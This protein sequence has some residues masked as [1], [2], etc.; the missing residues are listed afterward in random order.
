MT[1]DYNI[2]LTTTYLTDFNYPDS[3][4]ACCYRY[5]FPIDFLIRKGVETKTFMKASVHSTHETPNPWT[6]TFKIVR[7]W[8][9]PRERMRFGFFLLRSFC[10]GKFITRTTCARYSFWVL[11]KLTSRGGALNIMHMQRNANKPEKKNA[12]GRT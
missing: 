12:D 5:L 7:F 2:S 8:F 11:Y 6:S 1:C 4:C 3:Q 10:Y 9:T